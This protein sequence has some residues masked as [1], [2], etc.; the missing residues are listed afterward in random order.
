MH[1]KFEWLEQRYAHTGINAT[2]K[3]Q[4]KNL[5]KIEH[6]RENPMN[7]LAIRLDYMNFI[8]IL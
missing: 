1:D 8:K 2:P 7:L 5:S 4:K 3:Q 6:I